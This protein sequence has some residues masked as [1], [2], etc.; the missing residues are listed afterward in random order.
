MRYNTS[1]DFIQPSGGNIV[2]AHRVGF[3]PQGIGVKPAGSSPT[4]PSGS[5]WIRPNDGQAE[6]L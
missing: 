2:Q 5:L 6:R 3:D 1:L 4:L